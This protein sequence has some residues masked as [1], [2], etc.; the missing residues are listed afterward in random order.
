MSIGVNAALPLPAITIGSEEHKELFCRVFI[1]THDPYDP[2]KVA[3]PELDEATLARLRA[4]PFWHEAI[5]T[6]SD[7][8]RKVQA[9]A[10]RQS[11]ALLR[12]AIA[13]NGF[14][15]GRHSAL[16][17]HMLAHY[18]IPRPPT[19]AKPLSDDPLWDFMRV[20]YGECFDSFFA[21]GLYR[22]AGDSGFFPAPLLRAVEPIV[23]EEARHILFFVNWVAYCRAHE[24][25]AGKLSHMARC[26]L[27]MTMQIWDRAKTAIAAARG[28][29]DGGASDENDFMLGVKDSLEVVSSPRQFLAVCLREND[30]RMAPYDPRLLRPTFVPKLARALTR[31]LR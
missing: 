6:E 9:L 21:F 18:D 7:V 15:E 28:G 14:E 11:D 31:V 19:S 30:L 3:W 13:L 25:A 27:A 10:P 16:L 23:R 29:G 12:E 5:A 4:M 26:A 24:S 8:A 22:L 17:E 1:D 20:G 2:A